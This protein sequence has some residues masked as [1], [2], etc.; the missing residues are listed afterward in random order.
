M[1]T[2]FYYILVRKRVSKEELP[3][4][5]LML[6]RICNIFHVPNLLFHSMFGLIL[7]GVPIGFEFAVPWK[8]N[9][10][11]RLL[12]KGTLNLSQALDNCLRAV[13]DSALSACLSKTIPLSSENRTNILGSILGEFLL[14]LGT[15]YAEGCTS[16]QGMSGKN[17][18]GFSFAI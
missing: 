2:Y 6:R 10:N 15:R 8:S 1:C 16:G 3:S 4:S 14:L 13:G 9:L 11:P 18:I 17:R 12:E 5:S 7:L